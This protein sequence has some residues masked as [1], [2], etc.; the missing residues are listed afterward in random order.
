MI[1][2][3]ASHG[4]PQKDYCQSKLD[5]CSNMT[6]M[7]K[8][9]EGEN[10]G[11]GN[12]TVRFQTYALPCLE[13]LRYLCYR[14]D[15]ERPGL[16]VKTVTQEWVDQLNWRQ[17]AWWYQDDGGKQSASMVFSTHSFTKEECE[18]LARWLTDNGVRA[19]AKKT[20]KRQNTYWIVRVPTLSSLVLAENIRPYMHETML[21]KL[22]EP[23]THTCPI[24]GKA[25][26]RKNSA[27]TC[28]APTCRTEHKR[29][30]R[31]ESEARITPEQ[32]TRRHQKAYAAIRSDPERLEKFRTYQAERMTAIRN[33]PERAKAYSDNK[34]RWRRQRKQLGILERV[35]QTYTCACCGEQFQNTGRHKMSPR[36]PFI[37]CTQASCK[38]WAAERYADLRRARAREKWA[39]TSSKT[40]SSA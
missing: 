23:Q 40:K 8:V 1:R 18:R 13:F 2:Y 36:S 12:I 15:P 5:V 34:K 24:C 14:P 3:I 4:L 32:K 39:L 30:V 7:T 37:H 31:Q 11:W 19:Y 17:V 33:D 28:L 16:Y 25:Y 6:G 21:H 35:N 27:A 9:S 20:R 38:A 26:I 29:R 22:P 10:Q